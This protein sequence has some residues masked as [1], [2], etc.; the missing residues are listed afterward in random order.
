MLVH[1]NTSLSEWKRTPQSGWG[2][3]QCVTDKGLIYKNIRTYTNK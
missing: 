2:S 3:W 1:Q